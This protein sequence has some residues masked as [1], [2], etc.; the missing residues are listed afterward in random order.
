MRFVITFLSFFVFSSNAFSN[1]IGCY[2]LNKNL[3]KTGTVNLNSLEKEIKDDSMCAKNLLGKL[4]AQGRLF[5]QDM[6]KA[7]SIFYDLSQRGYNPAKFN[8]AKIIADDP[9]SDINNFAFFAAGLYAEFLSSPKDS[10]WAGDIISLVDSTFSKRAPDLEAREAQSIFYESVKKI[11]ADFSLKTKTNE[12]RKKEIADGIV[13][14]IAIAT[15][16]YSAAS[17]I[18]AAKAASSASYTYQGYSYL[19]TAT[20]LYYVRPISGNTL[21]MLPLN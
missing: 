4:Y 12:V 2:W 16:V 9:K 1:D 15:L 19:P 7:Y 5:S 20:N 10:D 17:A 11:N 14:T 3:A 8:M 13:A 6:E 18:S 21:Y